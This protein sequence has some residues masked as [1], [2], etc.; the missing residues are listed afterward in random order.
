MVTEIILSVNIENQPY[1][2]DFAWKLNHK[3]GWFSFKFFENG[4]HKIYYTAYNYYLFLHVLFI[5][6]IG[7]D[8]ILVVI[9]T[10]CSVD[11]R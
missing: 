3:E 5:V 4:F 9:C 11:K 1:F 10:Y 8:K 7:Y 6:W 2:C